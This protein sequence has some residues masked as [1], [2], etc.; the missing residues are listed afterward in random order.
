MDEY[1]NGGHDDDGGDV[2]GGHDD[3]GDTPAFVDL[4]TNILCLLHHFN[5]FNVESGIF[6]CLLDPVL[7]IGGFGG[8]TKF[9]GCQDWGGRRRGG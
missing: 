7:L 3:D 9:I 6:R 2:D 4:S 8:D 1:E 5:I